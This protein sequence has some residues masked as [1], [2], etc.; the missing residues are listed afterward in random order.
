MT[1]DPPLSKREGYNSMP[2]DL[3]NAEGGDR[4]MVPREA[5][6][7]DGGNEYVQQWQQQ[8]FDDAGQGSPAPLT[9]ASG[10]EEDEQLGDTSSEQRQLTDAA[11]AEAME[12]EN[13][14]SGCRNL[15]EG[16]R[17]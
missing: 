6:P 9:G 16:L 3:N 15:S 11:D 4:E 13:E 14:V 10:E 1:I 17:L 2:P 5:G 8:V 12:R 7:A